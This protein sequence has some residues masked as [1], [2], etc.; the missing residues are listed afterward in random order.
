MSSAEGHLLIRHY[1]PCC[2]AS[3]FGN[4]RWLYSRD[5]DV[6]TTRSK[7]H[8]DVQIHSAPQVVHS[9]MASL[10]FHISAPRSFSRLGVVVG[11]PHS[12]KYSCGVSRNL[13]HKLIDCAKGSSSDFDWRLFLT[14]CTT[15]RCWYKHVLAQNLEKSRQLRK[16]RFAPSANLNEIK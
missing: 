8:E 13:T 3:H 12:W 6:E 5:Q 14:F 4:A 16:T 15:V 9:P 2:H 7:H 10:A 11:D 1:A